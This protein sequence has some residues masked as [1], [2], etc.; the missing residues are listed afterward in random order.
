MLWPLWINLVIANLDPC[1]RLEKPLKTPR[2][3][4]L[5]EN[6]KTVEIYEDPTEMMLNNDSMFA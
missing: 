5:K 1:E 3:C 2:E 4:W 6:N